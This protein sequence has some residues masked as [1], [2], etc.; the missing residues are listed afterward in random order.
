MYRHLIG[1]VL[2]IGLNLP[3]ATFGQ[4][5]DGQTPAEEEVCGDLTGAAKGLCNAYCE[6][7]DCDEHERPSCERLRKNFEKKTG[8]RTLP[9]DRV[10]CGDAGAPECNGE[11]P[12]DQICTLIVNGEASCSCE[13]PP[14]VCAGSTCE[15]GGDCTTQFCDTSTGSPRCSRKRR[16][17]TTIPSAPGERASH[18]CAIPPLASGAIRS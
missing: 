15:E 9:C 6:A 2:A 18:S 13:A 7:Q 8:G 12:D 5:P 4:T 1:I 14:P 11:C 10:A 3:K 17:T 16:F